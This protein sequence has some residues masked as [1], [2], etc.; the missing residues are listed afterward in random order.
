MGV[1]V[2]CAVEAGF[3]SPYYPATT[4]ATSMKIR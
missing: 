1:S 2:A 3:P 4:G